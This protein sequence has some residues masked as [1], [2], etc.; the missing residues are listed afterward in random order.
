MYADT[1]G[2]F[3]DK[4]WPEHDLRGP[5]LAKDFQRHLATGIQHF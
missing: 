5:F 3:P 4:R 2:F 1:A